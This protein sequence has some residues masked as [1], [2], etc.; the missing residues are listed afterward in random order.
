MGIPLLQGRYLTDQDIAGGDN[1]VIINEAAA[2]E[3]WPDENPIGKQTEYRAGCLLTIVGVVKTIRSYSYAND[4]GPRFYIPYQTYH[5]L[6]RAMPGDSEFVVR[7]SGD[8]LDSIQA[9][10][11]EVAALDNRLPVTGFTTLEDRL[12]RSTARQGLYMRLLTTFAIM[13]L[14]VTAVGIY[15]V[16]SYSIARRT[17]EIG[18]RMALGAQRGDVLTLVIKKGLI[19]IV[20]GLVIG[21]AGALA[22]TRVLGKLLYGVTATDPATFVLVSLLLTAVGLVACYLPARRAT[23][24]D[25]MV[26][27]RYE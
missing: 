20:V 3:L 14:I 22:L 11:G 26:A 18:I 23:R 24:I 8:P 25:P 21:V 1:N 7:S 27:L 5:N 17:H 4:A 15:G 10:R 13:G 6:G 16:I 9:I 12:L 2:R 19:L